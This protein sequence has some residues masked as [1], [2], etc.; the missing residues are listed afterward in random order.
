MDDLQI[1]HLKEV[2][3]RSY[4]R[5]LYRTLYSVLRDFI[6][7]GE[8]PAGEK[9]FPS[10][11]LAQTLSVSRNTVTQAIE[12]L[13]S[14]G[15]LI[16]RPGDGVYVSYDI[17]SPDLL[18]G[19]EG[20]ETDQRTPALAGRVKHW[21]GV[22]KRHY[23]FGAGVA[24][25]P[26]VPAL[27]LF[28]F[29]VWARLLSRRWRLSG[30]K[31]AMQ[32]DPAGYEALRCELSQY[33]RRTRGLKCGAHQIIIVSGAQQGLDLL[34]RV[35]WEEGDRVAIEEPAFPGMDGVVLGN[36][37]LIEPIALDDEGISMD[38]LAG[39]TGVK[40]IMVMPSR[41]YPLGTA[42]SLGRRMALLELARQK[43]S[44]IIEDDFDCEFR[45]DGPPLTSL[46]GLDRDGRVIYVG[47]FSR[48]IFPALRLGFVVVP[49]TLVDPFIAA[50]AYIDGHASIIHQAVLADFFNEG[51]FDSHLRRMKKLYKERRNYLIEQVESR[52]SD[53]FKINLADGGLHICLLCKQPIEDTVLSRALHN[54]GI[55]ARPLSSFY[56]LPFKKQGLV[57]GFAGFDKK[58]IDAGLQQIE[59]TI[60]RM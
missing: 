33:L 29:D 19:G 45:F 16:A 52:L 4:Q 30:P 35:L 11:R 39:L 32:E 2:W 13:Q 42:M 50:K 43:C 1:S 60:K 20:E 17:A 24:F 53:Y 37:A 34:G 38:Y 51:Y 36:G 48:I 57:L 49:E 54:V 12:L 31:L 40:S 15:F 44:W 14:D 23:R 56:R 7:S 6:L 46:Q 27:D 8:L 47:T 21:Q 28:P 41:N 10:R 22:R 26:G 58:T 59:K 9:I 18:R 25:S 55:V 3:G 5:P